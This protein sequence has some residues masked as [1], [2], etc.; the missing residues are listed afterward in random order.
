MTL[1][2]LLGFF[3]GCSSHEQ[4]TDTVASQKVEL[5]TQESSLEHLMRQIQVLGR[6]D[7]KT[8]EFK[9]SDFFRKQGILEKDQL[10]DSIELTP[11]EDKALHV[12]MSVLT[13]QDSFYYRELGLSAQSRDEVVKSIETEL[14]R[15]KSY[16]SIAGSE[17]EEETPVR[18]QRRPIGG[19]PMFY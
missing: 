4:R 13:N 15:D 7:R 5:S 6:S 2:C 12:L 1:L 10:I 9:M 17:S 16:R 11:T 19:G 8:V 14:A 18:E 3:V